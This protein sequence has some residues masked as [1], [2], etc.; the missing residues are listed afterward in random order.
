MRRE[1]RSIPLKRRPRRCHRTAN[2]GAASLL[3][4]VALESQ[5]DTKLINTLP[6]LL[7]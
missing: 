6:N 5:V 4:R 1:G 7:Q 2:Q 3:L